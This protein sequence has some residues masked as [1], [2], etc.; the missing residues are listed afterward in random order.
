MAYA[1]GYIVLGSKKLEGGNQMEPRKNMRTVCKG[2]FFDISMMSN[3]GSTG[4][5][6]CIAEL[7]GPLLY[8]GDYIEDIGNPKIPPMPGAPNK[9]IYNFIAQETGEA[10]VT[11]KLLRPWLPDEVI[12]VSEYTI[13][14]EA[15]H[16]EDDLK[17]F[18]S[19]NKFPKTPILKYGFIPTSSHDI[20][21]TFYGYFP[22]DRPLPLYG[23]YTES[24]TP[25]MPYGVYGGKGECCTVKYGSP[26]PT[27]DCN[28]KYGSPD[29]TCDCNVKYGSPDPNWNYNLKYG[30]PD[31]GGIC[32]LKYGF[33]VDGSKMK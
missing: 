17:R 15:S 20:P 23:I 11:F 9:K 32:N 12:V 13:K 25:C 7:T 27:C 22:G 5:I 19:E 10:K 33:P 16:S 8:V 3:G 24:N 29:P 26:D 28:V 14:I 18:V 4:Y 30:S 6:W 31:P 21:R 2:E 1:D